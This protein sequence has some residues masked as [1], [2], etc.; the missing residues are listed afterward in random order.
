MQSRKFTARVQAATSGVPGARPVL[1]LTNYQAGHGM[2]TP[3]AAQ[4]EQKVDVV[5]FL[6]E[7]LG[8]K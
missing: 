1:L 2:G 7:Q 5:S 8:V 6:C 3:L 4:I